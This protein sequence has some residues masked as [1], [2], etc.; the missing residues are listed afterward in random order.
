MAPDPP[1]P[2]LPGA[3]RFAAAARGLGRQVRADGVARA[4]EAGEQAGA[5]VRRVVLGVMCAARPNTARPAHRKASPSG[6]TRVV[7]RS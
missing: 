2:M 3:E 7:P 6:P 1:V 5:R 4:L